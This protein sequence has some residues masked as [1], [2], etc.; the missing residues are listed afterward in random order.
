MKT[1]QKVPGIVHN[2]IP[3]SGGVSAAKKGLGWK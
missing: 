1:M 3:H 2:N